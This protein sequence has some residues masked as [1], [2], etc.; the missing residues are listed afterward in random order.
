M[1]QPPDWNGAVIKL[2][3]KIAFGGKS[4]QCLFTG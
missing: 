1:H 3:L 4:R 2:Q